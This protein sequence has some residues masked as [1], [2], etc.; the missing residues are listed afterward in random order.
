MGDHCCRC[1]RLAAWPKA[2]MKNVASRVKSITRRLRPS[3]EQNLDC[4][5]VQLPVDILVSVTRHLS[6]VDRHVLAMTCRALWTVIRRCDGSVSSLSQYQYLGYLTTISRDNP[7]LW[8]CESCTKVHP[9]SDLTCPQHGRQTRLA[10]TSVKLSLQHRHVQLAL[11][12]ER[13]GNLGKKQRER[14]DRLTV[15]QRGNISTHSTKMG[16]VRCEYAA[17][18]KIVKGRYLV[19]SVWTYEQRSQPI[20]QEVIEWLSICHH[21]RLD[22]KMGFVERFFWDD[23]RQ[24]LE[25]G[26]S[27]PSRPKNALRFAFELARRRPRTAVGGSCTKC[28]VDFSVNFSPER[29]TLRAW[30]DFGPEGTSLDPA[31]MVHV[32]PRFGFRD[33][34]MTLGHPEGSVRA[35][36]ESVKL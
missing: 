8:V 31:W 13:L 5:L 4:P 29:M 20:S 14:L 25:M 15:P 9:A 27:R 34:D 19:L 18:P 32:Q 1:S 17:Y 10:G 16:H 6:E 35:L 33:H 24:N 28:P 7:D 22:F 11:K 21:Q 3:T 2:T 26:G 23:E 12:L 36:Y 30:H